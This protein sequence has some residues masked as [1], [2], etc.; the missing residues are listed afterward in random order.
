V[1][2]E[3]CDAGIAVEHLLGHR[4]TTFG[5]G[6]DAVWEAEGASIVR[7]PIRAPTANAVAERW[8]PTVRSAC[9]DQ[10]LIVNE[11][12]RRRILDRDV[13]HDEEHRPHRSLA[14]RSPHPPTAKKP[15]QPTLASIRRHEIPGG[16]INESYAA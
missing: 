3:L 13:R 2:A 14:L 1:T 9:T 6:V 4:D 5:P 10:L 16:L 12:H 15:P 11:R 8:I 7:S